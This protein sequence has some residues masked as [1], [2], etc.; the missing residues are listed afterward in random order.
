[1]DAADDLEKAGISC[2]VID[3]QTLL[4]FDINSR[5]VESIK[6]TNRVIFADEDVPGGA[7]SFMMQQVLEKQNAYSYLDSK[8]VTI[9]A[10]EHRPAYASDGDYFS[11]PNAEDVFETVYKLMG[12]VN[13]L[14]FPS[15]Y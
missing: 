10:K 14:K 5:I 6:K 8:P 7:T 12:E 11:K 4:P 9:T 1:M 13:P 3:V 2:E 15:L